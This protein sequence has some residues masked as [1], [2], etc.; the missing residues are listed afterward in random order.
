MVVMKL[1][2]VLAMLALALVPRF[3]AIIPPSTPK[4]DTVASQGGDDDDDDD[5]RACLV[6]FSG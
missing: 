6:A 4:N 1:S 2:A 5:D 3:G